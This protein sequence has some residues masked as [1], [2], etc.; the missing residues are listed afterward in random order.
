M[1]PLKQLISM[2][3]GMEAQLGDTEIDERQVDR[4]MAIIK[5]MTPQEREKPSLL[6]ASRRRRIAAGAGMKVEDV[7]KLVKQLE[8]MQQLFKQMKGNG[9]RGRKKLRIPGMGS[10]EDIMRRGGMDPNGG[11]NF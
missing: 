10:F 3:P 11:F 1:G 5:S 4:T 6:N 8:M 9:A 7:N 2:I